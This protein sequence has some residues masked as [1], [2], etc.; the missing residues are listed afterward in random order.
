MSMLLQVNIPL[1][2][3]YSEKCGLRTGD[4]IIRERP[5][6]KFLTFT[7]AVYIIKHN[8]IRNIASLV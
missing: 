6:A 4:D 1:L 2:L 5:G 3:S 8:S 7:N